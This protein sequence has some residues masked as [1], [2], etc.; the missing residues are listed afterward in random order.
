MMPVIKPGITGIM[1]FDFRIRF[2]AEYFPDNATEKAEMKQGVTPSIRSGV[3]EQSPPPR[4]FLPCP[5][6]RTLSAPG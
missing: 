2:V 3:P 6:G 1:N 4:F 5:A